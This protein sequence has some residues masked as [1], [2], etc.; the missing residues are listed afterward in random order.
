MRLAWQ[1]IEHERQLPPNWTDAQLVLIVADRDADRAAALLGNVNPLR[2]GGSIRLFLSRDGGVGP[3]ALRR[4]LIRLDR[5]NI[6]GTLELVGTT[7]A[8]EA[9]AAAQPRATLV[10]QWNAAVAAL[11]ADWSDML[12]ELV[13]R[14]SDQL[15]RAALL[16][17]PMNPT[18]IGKELALRFRAARRFGYGTSATMVRRCLERLDEE[19]IPAELMVL[20]VLCDTDAVGTQGPVWRV[21]GKSV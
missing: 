17:A 9:T 19:G 21:A 12:G 1:L 18:R 8:E 2:R 20:R 5:Q 11:P 6:A 14:S 16:V 4:A 10:E 7:E 15:E 3:E 13:L